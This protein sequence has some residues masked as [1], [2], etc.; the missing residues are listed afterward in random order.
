ME[1]CIKKATPCNVQRK[2]NSHRRIVVL[3]V[4]VCRLAFRFLVI[5]GLMLVLIVANSPG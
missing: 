4:G 5:Y 1:L 2:T 3:P